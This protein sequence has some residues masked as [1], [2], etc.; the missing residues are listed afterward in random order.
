[1]PNPAAI[2][3]PSSP[4]SA[5]RR[6][7]LARSKRRASML[8]QILFY[9]LLAFNT[10]NFGGVYTRSFGSEVPL[11]PITFAVIGVAI[12]GLTT[13]FRNQTLYFK[14]AWIYW[15]TYTIGG[16]LGPD[17]IT[18]VRPYG[19]A[20]TVIKLWISII[21]VPWLACRVIDDSSLPRYAKATT[22]LIAL[23]SVLAVVQLLYPQSL[24]VITRG[25]GRGSGLWIDPNLGAT[26][27]ACGVLINLMFPF[28]SIA[29]NTGL[30]A[31][32]FCG[33][34]ATLSRGGILAAFIA[35][36]VYGIMLRQWTAV[37]R[38]IVITVL[39][40][41]AGIAA[42]EPLKESSIPGLAR[43]AEGIQ[44]MLMGGVKGQAAQG[45]WSLWSQGFNY[46]SQHWLRGRGHGSMHY[47]IKLAYLEH[48]GRWHSAGPHNYYILVWG[49]SGP[50]AL[51][52]FLVFLGGLASIAL[53]A[54]VRRIRAGLMALLAVFTL[55]ACSD[56]S[57]FSFQFFGAV[58]A[59]YPLAGLYGRKR[60]ASRPGA[61]P[62]QAV[63]MAMT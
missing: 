53:K 16:F 26:M 50:I 1:M 57:L 59:M 3:Y 58:F 22:L 2:Y 7:H 55:L 5:A 12:A 4:A 54:P 6:P 39:I 49:N 11:N 42:L 62:R 27:C 23:G 44:Q 60:P 28:R 20:Q 46:A 56:H 63:G 37:L 14:V 41:I 61:V 13:K 24:L 38:T 18:M 31:M 34:G 8:P 35:L 32:M 33:L 30:R 47:A 40:A 19:V 21:G 15:L 43:R 51:I 17:Q 52:A 29:I 36:L 9:L 25:G 48:E 45:R 10:L